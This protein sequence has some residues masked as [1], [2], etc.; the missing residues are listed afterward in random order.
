M[1]KDQSQSFLS[2]LPRNSLTDPWLGE[3]I[4]PIPRWGDDPGPIPAPEPLLIR[5]GP[6]PGEA[7]A[8]G[9]K[10]PRVG[11]PCT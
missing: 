3:G 5:A 6:Y 9:G 2:F 10:E 1:Q 7:A 4:M 11:A 8:I